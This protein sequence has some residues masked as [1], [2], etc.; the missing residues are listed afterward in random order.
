MY[1]PLTVEYHRIAEPLLT[2]YGKVVIQQ[3]GGHCPATLKSSNS[4]AQGRF[5]LVRVVLGPDHN[6]S[7]GKV[8]IKRNCMDLWGVFVQDLHRALITCEP[9]TDRIK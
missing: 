5:D 7:L 4:I 9:N 2:I 1:R 8:G 3:Y 6:S